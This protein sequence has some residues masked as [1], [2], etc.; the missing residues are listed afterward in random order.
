MN[1]SKLFDKYGKLE[2]KQKLKRACLKLIAA[3]EE[4]KEE[5]IQKR[6]AYIEFL[7]TQFKHKY[8]WEEK[9]YNIIFELEEKYV[10]GK[11]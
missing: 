8:I 6:F 11:R 2:R 10:K 9:I 3:L 7:L 4:D 5:Y 1:L